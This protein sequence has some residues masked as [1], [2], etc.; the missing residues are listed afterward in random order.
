M[1][2]PGSPELTGLGSPY[3]RLEKEFQAI[4][5]DHQQAPDVVTAGSLEDTDATASA[6]GFEE[7]EGRCPGTVSVKAAE[8]ARG[9]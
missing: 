4:M 6:N 8:S 5:S 3:D 2:S 1:A 7:P 9:V